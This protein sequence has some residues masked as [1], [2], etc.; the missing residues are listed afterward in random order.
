MH[1]HSNY[2]FWLMQ[3]GITSVFTSLE[4]DIKTEVTILGAGITGAL[5]AWYLTNAGFEVTVIDKRHA[6]MGSTAASTALLQYE[7]DHPLTELTQ[8]R[9]FNVALRSYQLC[10][11]A[12]DTIAELVQK[13]GKAGFK[14][15]PSLQYASYKKDLQ[16]LYD[17]YRLRKKSGFE[18]R[19]LE[20]DEIKDKFTIPASGAILSAAG[21]EIDPYLFTHNLLNAAIAK[22]CKV[23]DSTEVED[24][25][26]H[27][28]KT[29]LKT[30]KGHNVTTKY[31]VIATGYESDKYLP[32]KAE[33]PIS[34]YAIISKPLP[35]RTFWYR[36]AL[37]WE[38]ARPYNYLRTTQ[39]GRIIIGGKDD[40]FSSDERRDAALK[41]KAVQLLATFNKLMP[42]IPFVTDFAW[43]G[44]FS[45]T[46]DGL[47]YIGQVKER[48]N[49]FFTLGY[50]GNGIVFSVIAAEIIKDLLQG[51][52]NEAAKMFSF[53]R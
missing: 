39:T 28:N 48:K 4:G 47:P 40:D 41:T 43:T 32:K 27:N 20:E 2:P 10:L 46:K 22:G 24:I 45:S 37:I 36:N 16:P 23:Y 34:T 7:I 51:K 17:E 3:N 8:K 12:I 30:H 18:V 35:G 33:R 5:T 11:Q 50:G 6:G 31:L 26:H 19:W 9:G 49:T 52:K 1:L 25:Q 29:I 15:R 21:A 42:G 13:T 38:T 44:V 53:Y 14:R